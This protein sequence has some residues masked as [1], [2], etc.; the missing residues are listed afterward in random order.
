MQRTW[1]REILVW[2]SDIRRFIRA[3]ESTGVKPEMGNFKAKEVFCYQC[4]RMMVRHEEKETDVAIAVRLIEL[5]VTDLCDIAVVVTGD[6]DIVP[7]IKTAKRLAP[8]KRVCI[9][10]PYKRA[11]AELKQLADQ[12]FKL[13]ADSCDK[14]LFPPELILP[15]GQTLLQPP[16]WR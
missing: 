5:V 2:S 10:A 7:G 1:H 14:Y 15:N 9:I 4:R 11:N 16:S 3:L 8:T 13:R 12:Y 6:T